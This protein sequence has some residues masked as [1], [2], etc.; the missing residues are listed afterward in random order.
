VLP[1]QNLVLELCRNVKSHILELWYEVLPWK[2]RYANFL[3]RN[4]IEISMN[5]STKVH[6][7]LSE[8]APRIQDNLISVNFLSTVILVH[9]FIFIIVVSIILKLSRIAHVDLYVRQYK[10]PCERIECELHII[11][12]S[13]YALVCDCPKYNKEKDQRS[14]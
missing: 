1:R 7:N 2:H 3:W 11:L 5:F 9:R 10:S 8:V 13:L 6:R 4:P 14:T 12:V